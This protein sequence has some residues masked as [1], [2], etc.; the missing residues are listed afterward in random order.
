LPEGNIR[1]SKVSKPFIIT[2]VVLVFA[3]S[4]IGSLWMMSLLGADLSLANSYF[5]LHKTFQIDGFLT[6]LVMGVGY[7]IVPR[8]RNVQLSS[9]WLVYLSFGLVVLSL[10]AT[11][12]S[13]FINYHLLSIL[14]VSLRLVGISIFACIMIWTIRIHPRLLR[15][16]DYFIAFSVIM[17][18]T[19]NLIEII[20]RGIGGFDNPLSEVQLFL[21]F[22]LLMIFG[23]EYKTLPSLLGFI[24]PRKKLSLI[25]T[26]LALASIIIGAFSMFDD[27]FFLTVAFNTI[28]LAFVLTF[29]AAVHIFGGF[30]NSE[31]LRLIQDEKKAR[32]EY[33]V[34][35]LRISFLFLCLGIVLAIAFSIFSS[36][37]FYDLAIHYTAIGFLGITVA[38]YLPLMLPPI[39]GRMVHFTIFSSLPLLL[40]VL[41]L[42]IRTIGDVSVTFRLS[43]TPAT[44]LPMI[45]GWLVV[46]ALFV[47]VRMIHKSM[48]HEQVIE[49]R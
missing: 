21:L 17:L 29:A 42:A 44:Y 32:Y 43:A 5:Q 16:A 19:V 20:D 14:S 12:F 31:I 38:L 8:F 3:G 2:A 27:S 7:M 15:R 1:V 6:L 11:I 45:S 30:D 13:V 36:F 25:T 9:I 22:P 46:V 39:T 34:R 23:V 24:Y 41:A 48:I 28:L 47:F 35:H 10:A 18:V 33:I 26:W 49:K 40:V 37:I 4:I